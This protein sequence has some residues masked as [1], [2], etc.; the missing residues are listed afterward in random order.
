M[1]EMVLFPAEG[2][3]EEQT[4]VEQQPWLNRQKR[5][6][7]RAWFATVG[8]AMISPSRLMQ[9]TPVDS[10]LWQAYWFGLVSNAIFVIVGMLPFMIFPVI[11]AM[12]SGAMPVLGMGGGVVV[13]AILCPAV[14]LV[15][16]ALVV[17]GLL[18]LSGRQSEGLGRTFQA[19]AYSSGSNAVMAIP[20]LGIY[21][22][23]VAAIWWVVSAI[24]MLIEGQKVR[25]WRASICVTIP[26]VLVLAGLIVWS[27]M[28]FRWTTATMARVQKTS[29]T[30]ETQQVLTGLLAFEKREGRWP[31][32]AIELVTASDLETFDLTCA[33]TETTPEDIPVGGVHLDDLEDASES[34]A[35]AAV[36]SAEERLPRGVIAHRLGD[37]VFTCHGINDTATHAPLWLVIR[38]PDPD[39]NS[40]TQLPSAPV[41]IGLADGTTRVV[42]AGGMKSALAAQNEIRSQYGLAPLP[43]PAAVTHTAPAVATRSVSAPAEDGQL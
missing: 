12:G 3:Q 19:I 9:L 23:P 37:F 26:P 38:H 7:V 8:M 15:L 17:H 21:L 43:E 32:H 20:C 22:T 13:F 31:R 36:R 14:G 41:V 5:G 27:V 24:R 40:S 1:D 25:A 29:T 2:V 11:A 34:Q 35:N 6:W 33:E 39:A 42:P 4:A 10:S 30:V 16:F 28:L 18:R